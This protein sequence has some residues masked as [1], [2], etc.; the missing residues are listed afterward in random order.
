MNNKIDSLWR[1]V[2]FASVTVLAIAGAAKAEDCQVKIG[3]V[4]PM[5]G[6]ASAWGLSAKEAAEFVA[7]QVN[8]SGGLPVGGAKCKV[9][10]A[11][12]D[13]QYTAAGGA[14]A[15]NFLASEKI[16]ATVGPVG[17]PET[18]GFRPVAARNGIV[19]FST[20]YMSDV[21]SPEFPLAFHALQAP[22]TWGP[23]LVKKAAEQFKLKNVIILGPNDQGGTDG[24]NQ[25]KGIYE[26]AGV[27]AST[28]F[29]QRGTTNFAPLA[30]R[31]MA[32]NPDAVEIATVPPGDAAILVKQL[33]EAGFDGVIGSLGGVGLKPIE[34]GAGGIAN[35]KNVYWLET[36]PVDAPGIVRMRED[37]RKTFNKDAPTNPLFP[38]Y[39]LAAEVVL[40]GISAAGTDS[41]GEKIAA[42]LRSLTPESRY[43]G[44]A[45]WRGKTIYKINQELTFPPGIGMIIA[46]QKKPTTVVEIPA[47]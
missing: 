37:Y 31:I 45:G 16:H 25:L 44:K 3:A 9:T 26:S 40:E 17:S 24:S 21:I 10:V 12:Y 35:L 8:A 47:E 19:N 15:A 43:M 42:A 28:D 38:V 7:A 33:L 29:F 18:T 11:T 13:A 20:S 2:L 46:G 36:S 41:D 22:V 14:A 5:S 1:L 34:D 39:V 23:L 6:G 32:A 4:G 27:K 30:T